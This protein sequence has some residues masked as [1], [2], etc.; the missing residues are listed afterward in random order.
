[1]FTPHNLFIEDRGFL[2]QTVIWT[3]GCWV[4]HVIT[5]G[6]RDYAFAPFGRVYVLRRIMLHS[7]VIE[8][9]RRWR[10]SPQA[11]PFPEKPITEREMKENVEPPR[12]GKPSSAGAPEGR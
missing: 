4:N 11:F 3:G 6:D 9:V 5:S 1:L 7:R 8:S 12:S 2:V 10:G